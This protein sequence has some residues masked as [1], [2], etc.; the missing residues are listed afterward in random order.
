MA[1]Q[2]GGIAALP[3]DSGLIPSTYME[4]YNHL[5]L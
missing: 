1:Q 4:A 3:Q 2:R 5:E